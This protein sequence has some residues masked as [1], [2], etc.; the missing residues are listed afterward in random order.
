MSVQKSTSII[1]PISSLKLPPTV[2]TVTGGRCSGSPCGSLQMATLVG[3]VP[4]SR[5]LGNYDHGRRPGNSYGN[6]VQHTSSQR[7]RT[8]SCLS[9]TQNNMRLKREAFAPLAYLSVTSF[10]WTSL[11]LLRAVCTRRWTNSTPT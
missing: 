10:L 2:F 9:R 5:R 11:I 8:R 3:K 4:Y 7:K 6:L 1:H